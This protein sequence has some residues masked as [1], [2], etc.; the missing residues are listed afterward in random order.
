VTDSGIGIAPDRLGSV[1]TDFVQA[2]SSVS[3]RFGGSGLGLAICKR[4]IDQMNGMI[5]VTSIPGNGSTFTFSVTLP[6]SELAVEADENAG[7]AVEDLKER[8]AV[9]GRPLRI[10]LAEDNPTNQLVGRQMLREF[11]ASIS[12]A[13]N[14]AEAVQSAR[15]FSYDVILMDMQMPEMSGIEA[16]RAIRS[17]GGPQAGV[18]IVALTANA[19]P[20]DVKACLDA[21][22]NSFVAKPV[23]K[24]A[25]ADAI[26]RALT[27]VPTGRM[28]ETVRAVAQARGTPDAAPAD[29]VI[30]DR[31]AVDEFV[32]DVGVDVI[33]HM[34]RTFA[35]ETER[36]LGILRDLTI[37][38][39]AAIH[40]EAHT[41]KG[42][43]GIFGLMRF[44]ELSRRLEG[45]AS[46]ITAEELQ[47]ALGE[48]HEAFALSRRALNEYV[49]K[50]AQK[51]AAA[52]E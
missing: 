20:E 48:L 38:D 52:A 28:S 49:E 40:L 9:L 24:S 10:L 12:V 27:P 42:S 2:D 4:I 33:G 29:L 16:T 5:E 14:G 8:I 21:G 41:L 23:R 43:S 19:Y 6:L 22:M 30:L 26:L 46:D 44:S 37:G 13:S 34:L 7:S 39:R 45:R 31:T 32:E 17:H 36:R 35:S 50:I 51:S 18:P 25:L 47:L 15:D 1:F 3:R 11:D